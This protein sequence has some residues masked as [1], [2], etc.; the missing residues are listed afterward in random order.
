MEYS[1]Y[2]PQTNS[3]FQESEL[4][5][6]IW[7]SDMTE[8]IEEAIRFL[9]EKRASSLKPEEPIDLVIRVYPQDG[10]DA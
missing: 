10:D 8:N 5:A 9:T 1:I 6:G 4:E 7:L 3:V 2:I